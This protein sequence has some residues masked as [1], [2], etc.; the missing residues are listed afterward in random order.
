MGVKATASVSDQCTSTISQPKLRGQSSQCRAANLPKGKILKNG[1]ACTDLTSMD[2]DQQTE[3]FQSLQRL[4][5]RLEEKLMAEMSPVLKPRN[6]DGR[7]HF[8]T[9]LPSY[10]VFDVLLRE[11]APQIC[12]MGSVGSGLSVGDELLL[13]LMKLSRALTNQDLAYRFGTHVT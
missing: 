10:A 5:I 13:V 11:L 3:Q 2:I 8:Y 9:G 4:N 6:D 7:T 1:C 12:A